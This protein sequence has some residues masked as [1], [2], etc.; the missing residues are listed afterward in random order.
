MGLRVVNLQ[1]DGIV[2]T[3]VREGRQEMVE[4][5]M[6]EAVTASCG[7]EARVT[8]ERIRYVDAVD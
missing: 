3:G 4:D 2:V 5:T 8:L 7:Y 1:H 6:S